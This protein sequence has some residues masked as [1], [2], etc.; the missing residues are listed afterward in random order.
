MTDHTAVQGEGDEEN[1]SEDLVSDLIAFY[2]G[3]FFDC[4]E[5]TWHR[6]YLSGQLLPDRIPYFTSI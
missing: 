4:A 1:D 3:N 2:R 6:R 5:S